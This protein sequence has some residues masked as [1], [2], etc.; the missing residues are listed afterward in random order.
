MLHG[1]RPRK[2]SLIVE[3]QQDLEKLYKIECVGLKI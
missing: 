2:D 1:W 3:H